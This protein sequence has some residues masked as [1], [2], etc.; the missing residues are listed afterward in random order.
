METG[1]ARVRGGGGDE[2]RMDVGAALVGWLPVS[3][4]DVIFVVYGLFML[5]V[6]YLA[7]RNHGI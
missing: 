6:G 5:L 2:R 3:A 1:A 4:P 7:G